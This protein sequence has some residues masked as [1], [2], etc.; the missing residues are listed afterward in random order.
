VLQIVGVVISVCA[1]DEGNSTINAFAM[2]TAVQ[3]T[4]KGIHIVGSAFILCVVVED[5]LFMVHIKVAHLH[6]WLAHS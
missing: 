3:V 2:D 1:V 5:I 6:L 4:G